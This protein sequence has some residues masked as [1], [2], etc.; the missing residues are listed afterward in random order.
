MKSLSYIED[1]RCLK[2]NLL[3]IYGTLHLI[4]PLYN[5]MLLIVFRLHDDSFVERAEM[6]SIKKREDYRIT[7][8]YFLLL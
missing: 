8:L 6:C 2:V 1:A 4:F 5:S 7:K 3:A